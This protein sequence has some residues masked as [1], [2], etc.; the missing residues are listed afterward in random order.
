MTIP[1]FL[2]PR[3]GRPFFR[4]LAAA[5]A[6]AFLVAC[7]PV[8]Y[9]SGDNQDTAM[10]QAIAE[11][12]KSGNFK[13][14]LPPTAVLVVGSLIPISA[15]VGLFVVLFFGLGQAHKRR[16]AMI[17]K[18]LQ[19]QSIKFR[20]DLLFLF[21]GLVLTATGLGIS[22][23]MVARYGMHGWSLMGGVIP[24]FIGLGLIVFYR[25]LASEKR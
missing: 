3:F 5:L 13:D 18:G 7:V 23:W 4:L 8:E 17:E 24:F 10:K 25:V 21:K 2:F 12:I 9:R 6:L 22:L 16:M 19:P 20:W 15:T 11:R 1:S 14:T